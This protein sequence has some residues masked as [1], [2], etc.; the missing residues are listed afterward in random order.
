M[1]SDVVPYISHQVA[2]LGAGYQLNIEL[3]SNS[4]WS[5]LPS[6]LHVHLMVHLSTVSKFGFKEPRESTLE[7]CSIQEG[8]IP[9]VPY[10]QHLRKS[11]SSLP[12]LRCRKMQMCLCHIFFYQAHVK[13]EWVSLSA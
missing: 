9:A 1:L 12:S 11:Q 2:P 10:P 8:D 5:P 3:L 7:A 13:S 6:Q 4:R